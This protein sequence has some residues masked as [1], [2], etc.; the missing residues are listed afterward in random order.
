MEL[1][2]QIR[3]I[4]K[5]RKLTIA[6]LAEKVGVSTPHMSEVERG[7]KNL[8]NHLWERISTALGVAPSELIGVAPAGKWEHLKTIAESL[9]QSDL[10][11]LT[12]FA[13]ALSA[14][15]DPKQRK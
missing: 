8:N 1:N 12:R 15:S 7:K 6:E 5:E 2:I 11:R 14:S 10:D 4:R 3:R 9:S 13:E